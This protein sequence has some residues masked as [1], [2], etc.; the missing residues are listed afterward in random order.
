MQGLAIFART[1]IECLYDP[2]AIPTATR[3]AA[4]IQELYEPNKYIVIVDPFLGSGNQLYHMLKATNA[5][6]AY[7]IEK[8]PHI[9][10]QTMRNFAL[11]KINAA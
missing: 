5:S 4:I 10:Q 6:A 11:L 2:Y 7:G 1:G 9:Y 8:S 3:T